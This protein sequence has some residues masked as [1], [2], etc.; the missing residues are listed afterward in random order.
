MTPETRAKVMAKT[1]GACWFCGWEATDAAH[2]VANGKANR[3]K[4][5]PEAIDHED[6][7][8]PTCRAHNSR[9]M[10]SK[11]TGFAKGSKAEAEHMKKIL[12]KLTE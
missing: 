3:A 9:A 8:L 1:H 6:N 7:I 10:S 12:A 11:F 4:Y 5:T 2:I